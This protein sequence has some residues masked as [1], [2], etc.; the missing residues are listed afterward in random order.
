MRLLS[1]ALFAAM[2]ALIKLAEAQGAAIGEILFFRQGGAAAL[3]AGVVAAGPGLPALRSARMPA[4]VLRAVVGLTAMVFTFSAVLRLPLAEATTVN[5][6]VPIFATILGALVLR[7]PT[8][9]QRWAA[10]AAGFAGV[11]IVTQPAGGHL[12]LVGAR[13]GL[14]GAFGTASVSVLLRRLGRT[15][16]PLTT[17]FW[18]STLSLAVLG[19]YYL[20][21]A[22]AHPPL[23]WASLV[24]IGLFGGGAQVAMTNSLRLAPV[25]VVVPMDYTALIWATGFGWLLFGAL[26]VPAT[27]LGAPVI[28]GSGLFIVWREHVRRRGETR[29]AVG[30]GVS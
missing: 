29:Q 1:V 17:V 11:L 23:T 21:V 2:N 25:S 10:V 8:G 12:P 18:F 9:W 22:R 16:A 24:G 26:P 6:T 28:V 4:H 15:E 19:P 3:I 13:C 5:F 30:E 20:T 14:A 27:W 7:E